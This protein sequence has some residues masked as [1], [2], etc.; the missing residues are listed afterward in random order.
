MDTSCISLPRFTIEYKKGL[1]DFLDYIFY[2]EGKNGQISCPCIDCGNQ[3]W[4]NRT[5][6]TT[7][8]LCVG[9]MKG[10]TIPHFSSKSS[11]APMLDAEDD[12]QG[13]VNDAFHRFGDDTLTDDMGTQTESMSMPN[14]KAKKFYTVLGEAKKPLYPG[15]S[16]D[17]GWQVVIKTAPRHVYDMDEQ[18]SL[19]D[20]ETHLQ[21]DSFMCP[22][23]D[24][25]MDIEL[26]RGGFDGTVVD[27]NDL[28]IADEE[29]PVEEA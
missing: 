24:E 15:Y 19:D 6:A 26:V 14:L 4:V 25:T 20:V 13:L 2:N 11:D 18:T 5:E 1:D 10:Y 9:F 27:N 29:D 21:G 28:V 16:V 23:H 22:Q 3:T 17:K 8:L 12:M 7:H